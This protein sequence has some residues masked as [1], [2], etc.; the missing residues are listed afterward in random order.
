M[1]L[2]IVRNTLGPNTAVYVSDMFL[3]K[4]F[5]NGHWWLD[6]SRYSN[7]YLDSHYYH[8]FAEEPRSLS[9]R[10]HIAYVCQ[11][12]YRDAI[13]CCYQNPSKPNNRVGGQAHNENPSQG[14]QRLIGE[15]SAATDI[16][17]V[18]MLME[19]MNSIAT[20]GTADYLHRQASPARQEFL[21]HF[22][23]AQI[24]AYEAA[25][26][27]TSGG[28]FYWT[29]KMEGGAFLEWDY[30]RAVREGWFPQIPASAT[31]PS[32]ELYG[33]CYD[34]IF[35][36]NDDMSVIHEFPDPAIVKNLYQG[37]IIDDDVVVS[38]GDSLIEVDGRYME[39]V[40]HALYF[41]WSLFAVALAGLSYRYW[42]TPSRKQQYT[43]L[44]ST[45]INGISV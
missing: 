28:W 17:P 7:T 3:A 32:Q 19:V 4:T 33:T 18:N 10:Q 36:T 20:N 15:W 23:E 29:A 44:S 27:G 37:P 8:V 11:N 6:P 42:K 9:P 16:L 2:E 25:D 35:R 38:H 31:Q 13:S 39:P 26:A 14:V 1:G 22:I 41:V 24:V 34:I 30:L 43:Q 21:K 5:N 40:H 45:E 12:E